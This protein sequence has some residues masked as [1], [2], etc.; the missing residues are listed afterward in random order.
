M[1]KLINNF[2]MKEYDVLVIGSGPAGNTTA[3]Y[4]VRDG[5][6][7]AIFTGSSVGGQLTI[8]TDVENFPAFPKPIR[9]LD[10]M[11]N[12][13]EQSKNLGVDIVYDTIKKVDF[14]KRPF[15]CETE[16]GEVYSA[17]NLV[18]ATGANTRWL[19]LESE[20]RFIGFGVSGCATCDG[21]FFRNKPVAVIGGGDSA[22][23]E[24]LHMSHIA[25]K[26]YLIYR[27]SAFSHMQ[28]AISKKVL[29]DEKIEILFDTEVEEV[30]GT[31]KPKM[32]TSLKLFNN[33]N[34]EKREI[35]VDAMFV[36]IG[37]K[38]ES[39]IFA[40]SGLKIDDKGYII[41]EPDSARTNIPFVY[42]VGDV[43]NKKYKQAIIASGYG[44]IASLEI[45]E[46]NK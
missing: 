33:K 2:F 40:N 14:S 26:V 4:T 22:G 24:A 30:C 43:A 5:L 32:M 17:K 10:L 37:R 12:M 7:T 15:M 44:A 27:S 11:N 25:S 9:G 19:G 41:T 36:A 38:P 8:T 28:E 13:L 20:K 21:N 23:I 29:S 1:N 39:N 35:T 34:N 16:G 31:E 3:I 18:I 46:D 6:K 45:E 42:A